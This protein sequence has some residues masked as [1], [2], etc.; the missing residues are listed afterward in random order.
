M[1]TKPS[2]SDTAVD[3]QITLN[4]LNSMIQALPDLIFR[5]NDQGYLLSAKDDPNLLLPTR[6][7]IGRPVTEVLPP[8]LAR[9]TL[10]RIT[11]TLQRQQRVC[12]EYSITAQGK[13]SFYEARMMPL[14]EHEVL[15][16]ARDIT[17]Q[18]QARE[19]LLST[20]KRLTAIF[21]IAPVGI[22]VTDE[23][24]NIIDCNPESERLLGISKA[25]HLARNYA[26]HHWTIHAEDDSLLAP[27]DFASVRALKENRSIVGQVQEIRHP[28]FSSWILVSATPL[29]LPGYGV[30][31]AYADINALK[32]T[33]ALL[34]E[35]K[36]ELQHSNAE[37]EQFSYVASHD[38]RQPLRMINSYLELLH[39]QLE[40]T[41]SDEQQTMIHFATE[42]AARLDHMLVSLLEYSRVG[43]RGEP[44]RRVN[45]ELA[46][47]EALRFLQ[48]QIDE[49]QAEIRFNG[50]EWPVVFASPDELTRLLQNL[51][52]N[53]IKYHQPNQPPR[54]T[55]TVERQKNFWQFN[56]ID[57]GIGIDPTQFDRLFRVFQRLHSRDEFE[58]S[59]IGL[60]ICRKIVERHGGQISVTSEGL[61]QGCC[62]SF[63]LPA[64][65]I[66]T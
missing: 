58:G 27:E 13:T 3:H 18:V 28:G 60:A 38:L 49:Q 41:L 24:G 17:E 2:F 33:E 29:N 51:I 30:L 57:Q 21:D 48:P 26:D 65:A 12:Y 16:I 54:I 62:F 55:L 45:S 11:E 8:D 42:A 59:G 9:L 47:L 31:I 50:E 7:F 15:A 40:Q 35:Q 34:A 53:S 44:M 36:A 66:S 63:T 32:R 20:Q 37:L 22:S 64:Q 1:T 4:L 52:S 46:L 61:N 14:S 56:I 5:L 10:D 39:K 25:D 6:D 43:R 19:V 23:Q